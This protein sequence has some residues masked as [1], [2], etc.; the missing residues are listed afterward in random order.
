MNFQ[1][2]EKLANELLDYL[3]RKPYG[4][5]FKLISELQKITPI[6]EKQDVQISKT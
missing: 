6:E 4:E 3:S 1:I 2:S 5:V